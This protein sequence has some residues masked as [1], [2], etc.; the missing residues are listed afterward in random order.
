MNAT[1]WGGPFA[2]NPIFMPAVRT[3][4]GSARGR[5]AKDDIPMRTRS[6]RGSKSASSKGEKVDVTPKPGPNQ[7]NGNLSTAR[8]ATRSSSNVSTYSSV[9]APGHAIYARYEE[10][11]LIVHGLPREFFSTLTHNDKPAKRRTTYRPDP[12][13]FPPLYSQS[14]DES[15]DESDPDVPSPPQSTPTRG[16]GV[17]GRGGRGRGGRARAGRGRG[18]ARGSGTATGTPRD[19]SPVRT[20]P[21][22]N[23]AP[24]YSLTEEDDEE[25][26]NQT[27]PIE[28]AKEL[29][30]PDEEVDM[31]DASSNSGDEAEVEQ[32]H[33]IQASSNTPGG[34]P[35]LPGSRPSRAEKSTKVMRPIPRISLQQNSGSQTPQEAASTPTELPL[36]KLL[37]PADDVLSDSDLPG[38]WMEGLDPPIEAECEDRADYL[39][40]TRY[41]P[42]TDAHDIIMALTKYPVSQRSTENLYLLAENTQRILKAWQDEYLRLDGRTAP[43][44]HPPKKPANGGRIPVASQVF[45][46]M[47]EAD[48][49]GYVFDPKRPPGCQDPF[50][51]RIGREKT[52]GRELRQRR[53]R[54]ML[55]SAAPSDED[56]EEDIE[57]RPGKRQRRATRRFEIGDQGPGTGTVTGTTTPKRNGW[58]GARKRGV[59]KYS[60]GV[61]ETPEPEGRVKRVKGVATALLHQRVQEM[62]EQSAVASSGDEGGPI[63]ANSDELSDAQGLNDLYRRRGRPAGSKNTGRRSDF[64]VKKGPRGPRKKP[65]EM[66]VPNVTSPTSENAPAVLKSLSQGQNQFSIDPQPSVH[67]Q[68]GVIGSTQAPSVL[69]PQPIATVFQVTTSQA[70][71]PGAYA[72]HVTA[73]TPDAYMAMAPMNQYENPYSEDSGA[74]PGSTSKRKPRVKSEKRSQSMTIWWAER[75]ARQKEL[76]DK[77]GA[78]KSATAKSTSS[79]SKRAPKAPAAASTTTS[80]PLE[81][82]HS[83][84]FS[85]PEP[86]SYDPYPVQP[87]LQSF[88]MASPNA[89]YATAHPPT[90]HP[91]P[92]LPP[93]PPPPNPMMTQNS[94]LAALPSGPPSG[95]SHGPAHSHPQSSYGPPP[96]GPS[97]GPL[98]PPSYGPPPSASHSSP[99]GHSHGP[100]LGHSQSPFVGPHGS[101]SSMPPL[102]PAPLPPQTPQNYPSPYGPRTAPRPKSSGPPPLAPAPAHIS[103]YPPL[104]SGPAGSRDLSFKVMLP[105]PAPGEEGRRPSR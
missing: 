54:D 74:T 4:R 24:M 70:Q 23:A 17:R 42:M 40:K 87:P 78:S 14:E 15:T 103:P 32:M 72:T 12:D 99:P 3:F 69:A 59:S 100:S 85:R 9:D 60:H 28:H 92:P 11:I 105:G 29:T 88:S 21:V 44:A 1:F 94:P 37:D 58:G 71:D 45:E 96:P 97:Y 8:K 18:R 38:P 61:S 67:P 46:D 89:P 13:L 57:G 82:P 104:G 34:S 50:A 19:L 80:V 20:R 84:S 56:E 30:P 76:D 53:A 6:G 16:R 101:R 41:M 36:R 65:T 86:G 68:L 33:R 22:R 25:P 77:N 83:L 81:Q 7:S 39:L 95:P 90:P 10:H 93:P 51:Q 52:N 79:A 73:S 55:D 49:Y 75:K 63:D 43:H 2:K 5:A 31:D 48:L 66:F 102:A 47:K 64:G 27:S 98:P 91:P 62:R 26:S 35:P